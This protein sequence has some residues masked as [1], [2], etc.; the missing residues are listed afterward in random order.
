M[1]TDRDIY[2]SASE[3][4]EQR[5]LEGASEFAALRMADLRNLKDEAG[6]AA[7]GRIRSALLDLSDVQFNDDA[8]N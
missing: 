5:G 8:V 3:L 7:W 2:R 1:T 4:I 6:V